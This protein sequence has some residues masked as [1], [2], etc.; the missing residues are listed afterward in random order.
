MND[1][2]EKDLNLIGPR[3][4]KLREQREYSIDTLARQ[5]GCSTEMITALEAG[6]LVPSLSPLLRLARGL[7]VRLGTLLD[8]QMLEGPVVVRKGEAGGTVHFSGNDPAQKRA[9]LDFHPLAPRKASRNMEPF[10]IDVHPADGHVKLNEHEG[11]E[12]LYVLSGRIEILYGRES[13]QLEAGDSIYYE[14][15]IPHHVHALE[16]DAR[17]LAV[18]YAPA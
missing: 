8:D 7:G 9:T 11:E 2:M 5:S 4:R 3:M 15:V 6:E 14:S 18:V 17:M 12:F 1:Q 13:Y 10:L 16:G